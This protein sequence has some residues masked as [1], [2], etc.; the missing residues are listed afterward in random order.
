MAIAGSGTL[1][2]TGRNEYAGATSLGS[3]A[4]LILGN[5]L[6]LGIG[7]NLVITGGSLQA[8]G[9]AVSVRHTV[10]ANGSFTL[11]RQLTLERAITLG[12]DLTITSG[13]L[14]AGPASTST[15]AGDISGGHHLTFA[16]GTHGTGVIALSGNNS[17]TGGTTFAR[18]HHPARQRGSPRQRRHPFLHRRHAPVLRLRQSRRLLHAV[19]P[20]WRPAVPPR[21]EWPGCRDRRRLTGAGSSL[22]KLG[23]GSLTITSFNSY[24]GGTYLEGGTI[25][26]NNDVALG[27]GRITVRNGAI[28]AINDSR[29]L[30]NDITLDGTLEVGRLTNFTGNVTVSSA[31]TIS[32][33]N[34]DAP[35]NANSVF[36][37][38]ISGPSSITIQE[39][40]GGIGTGAI[41]FTGNNTYEGGTFLKGGR[42]A[43]TSSAN[44]GVGEVV[45][46]GGTL[47]TDA[48][49]T[50]SHSFRTAGAGTLDTNGHTVNLSEL[51][52][53]GSFTQIGG[54]QAQHRRQQHLCGRAHRQ[55]QLSPRELR[56]HATDRQR[57]RHGFAHR[58]CLRRR[59]PRLR[60]HR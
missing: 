34:P 57:R 6:A 2:L 21:Y 3:N 52:G 36:S 55:R 10:T 19:Q 25:N 50:F 54:G 37:G 43:I 47:R 45:F 16:E 12:S 13:N 35:A 33:N 41:V 22:H 59:H 39:G 32:T 28:R 7:G 17:H 5:D 30:G 29:T 23:A 20:R 26:V 11:G 46:D 60:P 4:T 42:L 27:S 18:R 8:N 24:D 56:H 38:V 31:S 44:L 9:S 53:T 49:V 51:H 1:T 40:L 15:I 58:Q 48:N 14:T